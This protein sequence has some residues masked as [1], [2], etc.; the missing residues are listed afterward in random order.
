VLDPLIF[1]GAT[2]MTKLELQC[3]ALNLETSKLPQIP[4]GPIAVKPPHP[5]IAAMLRENMAEAATVAAEARE[6]SWK[7]DKVS[8]GTP[9]A[10]R[11]MC[12]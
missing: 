9:A 10:H 11:S 6:R 1:A 8:C 12:L 5:P 7:V 3:P 2:N 4:Q